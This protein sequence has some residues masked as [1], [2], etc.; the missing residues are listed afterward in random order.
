VHFPQ[1]IRG[2]GLEV[3]EP[4]IALLPVSPSNSKPPVMSRGLCVCERGGGQ[5]FSGVHRQ[6]RF[7]SVATEPVSRHVRLPGPMMAWCGRQW[8]ASAAEVGETSKVRRQATRRRM[9]TIVLN[10]VWIVALAYTHLLLARTLV[11]AQPHPWDPKS[12]RDA[13]QPLTPGQVRQ[14]WPAFSH[15]LG[16]L[17]QAPRPSGKSPGGAAGF[18]PTPRTRFQWS[19]RSKNN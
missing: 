10:W 1:P 8:K 19:P 9:S 7:L 6:G 12:R 16:T 15:G 18:H 14:A 17:A 2:L 13:Q 5:G 4:G 3:G 11:T